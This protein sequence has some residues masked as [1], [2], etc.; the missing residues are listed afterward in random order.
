MKG[1]Q[2]R[3]PQAARRLR[4]R[5]SRAARGLSRAPA[6]PRWPRR[7]R[8]RSAPSSSASSSRPTCCPRTSSACPSSTSAT[9]PS[10][11]TRAR[12]S[13]TSC[14]PTRSTAPR[15]ARSPRCSRRW[16]RGRSAWTATTHRLESLFFV[17]ATQNPVEFRGTYPLPEAQMDRFALQFGLGYVAPDDEVAILSA[18]ERAHPID[19]IA[20]LSSPSTTCW[21]CGARGRDAHQ[22][23]AEALRGRPR[24]ASRA[25]AGRRSSAPARARRSRS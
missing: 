2:A 17:I 10:T 22:R 19:E 24:A 25:A 3:H 1:Q 4:E 11:S 21:R 6:R 14:S 13:P 8:A 20:A 7:S 5:R 23:R 15:R 18:Q 9:R 12:S 16:P